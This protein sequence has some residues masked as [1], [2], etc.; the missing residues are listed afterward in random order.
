MMMKPCPW[1]DWTDQIVF[2]K[3]LLESFLGKVSKKELI[4]PIRPQKSERCQIN[5]T[6]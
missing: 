3:L 6:L 4:R 1:T 2:L 5:V